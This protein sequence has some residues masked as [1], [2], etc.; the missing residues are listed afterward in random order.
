MDKGL[1][2]GQVDQAEAKKA[3]IDA[4]SKA[5][6]ALLDLS[7]AWEDLMP[8]KFMTAVDEA[9]AKNLGNLPSFD[10]FS[11]E[12]LSFKEAV[13]DA[14]N[15]GIREATAPEFARLGRFVK[16]MATPGSSRVSDELFEL[17]DRENGVHERSLVA[18]FRSRGGLTT[19]D[20]EDIMEIEQL[21]EKAWMA[22]RKARGMRDS[23]IDRNTSFRQ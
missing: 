17:V 10:D 16:G 12:F 5:S 14:K 8:G 9:Y 13:N 6:D 11:Y 19:V 20:E 2:E 18:F 22:G 7:R 3:F 15:A 23:G 4:V 21:I 1:K